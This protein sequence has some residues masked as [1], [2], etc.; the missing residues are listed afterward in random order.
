MENFGVHQASSESLESPKSSELL[1]S[2]ESIAH[3][4]SLPPDFDATLGF[5]AMLHR[6]ARTPA[7]IRHIH[8]DGSETYQPYAHL[9]Q[10][11][12]QIA[13]GLRSHQLQPGDL[14]ILQLPHCPD[15]LVALWGCCLS[16]CVPVPVAVAPSYDPQAHPAPPLRAALQL[17]EHPTVL[18]SQ[19]LQ[20]EMQAFLDGEGHGPQSPNRSTNNRST[21]LLTLAA[22]RLAG[23][24][25]ESGGAIAPLSPDDLALLLL[26]SGS[27]GT[28]KGVMLSRRNLRVSAYGMATVN[29]LTATD[30]TLNW[31]PLEH[32]ASLVMFHFTEVYLGCEQIHVA[33]ER[34]LARPLTWL[35]LLSQHRVTAT[36]APNFAY[37][38]VN[39]QAAHLEQRQWDL[40]CVRW[41]GNGAEAVVGETT[42]RFLDRLAPY[43]LAATAVS[44]GYGL[45][46]TCS[47]IVHSH[48]FSVE[49]AS[50][51]GLVEVGSPIP[52]VSLRI[53]ND[54]NQVLPEGE[55]G[56]LQVRGLA[57]TAGYYRRPDLTAEA[58]TADGWF[59]TGDL[60]FLRQGRLTI[61][62]RQKEVIILNG[63]NYPS[64]EIEAVVEELDGVA[65]SFTAACG[66]R[67][68][69]DASD[70]LAVFFHPLVAEADWA[71]LLRQM[72]RQ[73]RQRLG[74]VPAYLIPVEPAAIP[75]T[76]IGKIQRRSLSQRFA[77]GEF[78]AI[79]DQVKRVTAPAGIQGGD[80]P[81]SDLEQR[82]AAI[83]QQVLGL[84]AV[85]LHDNFFDLGGNSL[86]LMQVLQQVQ[87]ALAA[88]LTAVELF[89]YPT[90]AALARRIG[91]SQ[92]VQSG[93]VQ[94]GERQS[95]KR[96]Q[97]GHTEIAVIGMAGRFPGASNLEAFWQNLRAGVESI[98]FFTPEEMVAAGVAPSL[99][100]HPNY[101]NASP[102]LDG[103]EYFDAD[104]FGYSPREAELMDPQ[105]RLLLECAWESLEHA[106]YDSLTYA[107]PI[108]LFAGAAMNTYLL[109]HVYP[110][111]DRLDPQDPLQVF[112]LSSMGGFQ[113]TVANDKDYLT[114]RISYKLNLRGPSINVQTAC[115]TSLVAVHLAAQSLLAGECA[116]ALAGG[117][118]VQ[119]PQK[120]GHL[121]QEGMILSPDGHCRAFDAQA[122][123]TIFGSGVGLVVLKRLEQAIADRDTI[124]AVIKGSAVGNDG[125]MKV[126]YF[127]PRS[128]GQATVAA[129]AMAIAGVEADSIQYL[130]AHG[131]GTPLGDPIEIAG[132]TQAFRT[133]T[134]ARQFCA[135]GSVKTNVG[136]LNIASGIVGL[137]KT[138]L[139]LHHQKIP[140]SLHF[141]TPNPQIDFANSP[142]YVNTTLADWPTN[143]SPRRA[144][145]N[146]LG[147]GGTNVH[148]VLEESGKAEGRGQKAEGEPGVRSQESGVRSQNLKP[149]IQNPKSQESGVRI[150]NLKPKIQNPKSQ[151]SG[152][153][154]QESGVRI[155]NPKS[156]IQNP[157]LSQFS[158]PICHLKSRSRFA[159]GRPL[160]GCGGF[161]GWPMSL[162]LPCWTI[163][164][165]IPWW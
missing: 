76:A 133:S 81:S 48:H 124:Y 160:R 64:H 158:T 131:T 109:N 159:R 86:K 5:A 119:T 47:G 115:S 53:V 57:V 99:V 114:T 15:F 103:T 32:V 23:Q 150:Q 84:Q 75:K 45:S 94:V 130:E 9:W 162:R 46:E 43:G 98:T 36:W 117:V 147:I 1:E 149:K 20:S 7:G 129:T 34:V 44:P 65:V 3:G 110:N 120:A 19:S 11:A 54:H 138:V 41:M 152:V 71:D 122:Q 17:L 135:I 73:V 61:T 88:D 128:E 58:F 55:T 25:K 83:W 90:V 33:H 157:S 60:G 105:H 111:R 8:A 6:A 91:P 163:C 148:V 26:T 112:T 87:A 165:T 137:L 92:A 56:L 68:P 80:R 146:S 24:G 156:K 79:V 106:G 89:Q 77:A 95:G 63:V 142:F 82:L 22:I 59:N 113:A 38:L 164:R 4:S 62:G 154:S 49:N 121:F 107:G 140:P 132:L 12:Q 100:R 134:Q 97:T 10:D 67:R 51:G 104:F 101:V 127:A 85:G 18:T 125:G 13:A 126:G 145:V 161:W 155:Q 50:D 78:D 123:G 21:K 66:V 153:R 2:P 35:D 28:P 151:E 108:G 143:G 72:R 27:T 70:Q 37:G 136:H 139:A 144:G 16:G 40:S 14:V 39:E 31:M 141:N 42:R 69:E 93:S 74:I 102:T 116:M 118:S 29:R 96:P 52:G 30:I